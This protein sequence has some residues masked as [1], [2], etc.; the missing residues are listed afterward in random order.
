MYS[1]TGGTRWIL[2][3]AP[4][5]R[6]RQLHLQPC[7]PTYITYILH[8]STTSTCSTLDLPIILYRF[9]L[10]LF[11]PSLGMSKS[12]AEVKRGY[13]NTK[14]CLRTCTDL[15]LFLPVLSPPV[16]RLRLP[17]PALRCLPT[18]PGNQLTYN[19]K[20]Y[21]RPFLFTQGTDLQF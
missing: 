16:L 4:R 5:L 10:N 21:D 9:T 17:S 12:P 7:I 14:W 15:F 11:C 6:E 18:F 13:S 20:I 19:M 1:L 2:N 8:S 3:T